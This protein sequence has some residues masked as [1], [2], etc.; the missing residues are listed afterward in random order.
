MPSTTTILIQ[1][2][3][4][5]IGATQVHAFAG[6]IDPDTVT[7]NYKLRSYTD[8]VEYDLI[9]SDEFEREGRSFS[10]GHDP[11]WTALDKSDDDQTAQGKKSLQYYNR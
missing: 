7:E 9:M 4:F 2:G 3:A 6:W 11:M 8:G 5:L 1:V 10:D